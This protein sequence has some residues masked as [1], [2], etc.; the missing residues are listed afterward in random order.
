MN[1]LKLG[2][3]MRRIRLPLSAILPLRQVKDSQKKVTRYKTIV[4]SIKAVGLLEPLV[5]YPQ[6]DGQG[7]YVLV[8][9]N[10]RYAALKD[11]G[12]TEAD[13]IIS[14]DD[15]SFTYN[16]RVNRLNPIQ[17]HKMIMKAVK[18]GVQPE[19]IAAALN[20][21]LRDVKASMSLLDGIHAEAA[22]VLKDKSISPKAIRL[23]KK[24]T[25]VRQIEIAELMVSA[26]NY[27]SGY[28]E[29][30]V[31]GTP[32][33]QLAN[34]AEPKA[35]EGLSPE[36]IA[37]LEQEMESLEHDLKAVEESYGDNVLN[38]TCARGYIK[39]LLENAKV[40]RFLN[41]NYRDIFT[42]FEALAAT[43]TL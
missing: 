6:K 24:V 1:E 16:A 28:A 11:L 5:V 38:L 20:L 30:L 19:R 17:E 29:A 9:G 32:K 42:Q 12:E 43:E 37:R 4:A 41:G 36:D 34:P 10:V 27:T 18:N 2:F 21:P 25:A 7:T 35:K 22:D 40:V 39:K 23:L 31:L 14:T 26:S 8:E 15:E 3:E 33:D 13:C